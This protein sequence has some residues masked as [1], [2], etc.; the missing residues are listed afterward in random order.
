MSNKAVRN[1]SR[2]LTAAYINSIAMAV[3]V[4]GAFAQVIPLTREGQHPL[5]IGTIVTICILVSGSLHW[6]AKSSL[7]GLEE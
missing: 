4:V 5:S 3:M 6:V 7:K 2:K 1:E